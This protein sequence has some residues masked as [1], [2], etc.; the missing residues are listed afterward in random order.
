[1]EQELTVQALEQDSMDSQYCSD[2]RLFLALQ[3][4]S[5]A[6]LCDRLPVS[7]AQCMMCRSSCA[8]HAPGQHRI[9]EQQRCVQV[10]TGTFICTIYL[11]PCIM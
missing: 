6:D 11:P 9:N 8:M 4:C 10:A 2:Q 1:M 3:L 5:F 7:Q